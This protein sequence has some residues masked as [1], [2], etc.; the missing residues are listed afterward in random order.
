MSTSSPTRVT[1]SVPTADLRRAFEFYKHGLGL[2]LAADVA[3]GEMPEPVQFRLD[4]HTHLMLVPT[5]GFEW[6]LG[7]HRKVAAAGTSECVLGLSFETES[8]VNGLAERARN[9]GAA[10]ETAPA[11]LPWGYA[12]TVRDLDGHLWMFTTAKA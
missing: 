7:E 8:E 6:V 5:R 1:I 4:Q 9:A 2:K 3:E 12:A 11:K 10:I